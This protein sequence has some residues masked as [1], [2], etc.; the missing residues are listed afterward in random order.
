VEENMSP[1]PVPSEQ[2]SQIQPLRQRREELLKRERTAQV[3]YYWCVG[4]LLACLFA[5]ILCWWWYSGYNAYYTNVVID[6]VLLAAIAGGLASLPMF[7]ANRRDAKVDIED[8]DFRIDL[9]SYPVSAREARA[10]KL[11]RLN[12]I[13]LRRYYDLNLN[14]N[15]WVFGLGIVCIALGTC[16]IGISL[17]LVLKVASGKDAQIITAVLGGIGAFLTNFVAA[18]YLKI[19]ASA[20]E[21]LAAFHSRLVETHQALFGNLLASRIED[22]NR[23]WDALGALALHVAEPSKSEGETSKKEERVMKQAA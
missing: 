9:S 7:R 21:T 14:Q 4:F 2:E 17:Y 23:R 5:G 10:E 15:R 3:H 22:D 16:I 1:D 18:I 20:T 13:Q 11:L 8:T 6:A 12:D 19:N